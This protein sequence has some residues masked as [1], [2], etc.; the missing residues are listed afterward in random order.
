MGE[1][2]SK[3]KLCNPGRL[4]E[5]YLFTADYSNGAL[6]RRFLA[7]PRAVR[8]PR[9]IYPG[10]P[11][12]GFI[13]HFGPAEI[14]LCTWRCQVD[15]LM[16]SGSMQDGYLGAQPNLAQKCLSEFMH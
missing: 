7:L 12:T 13:K 15:C 9:P 3:V 1:T 8:G 14:M 6:V 2:Y 5:A 10:C 16:T 11:R 4:V